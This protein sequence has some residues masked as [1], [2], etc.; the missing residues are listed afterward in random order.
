MTGKSWKPEDDDAEKKRMD[1][2][3]RV[4]E[5]LADGINRDPTD[6]MD[7]FMEAVNEA[8]DMT[9]RQ[10][11]ILAVA[12]R[13]FPYL[14]LTGV[15]DTIVTEKIKKGE[16]VTTPDPN[17]LRGIAAVRVAFAMEKEVRDAFVPQL[18][19]PEPDSKP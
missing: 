9:A 10:Q 3:L 1:N 6:H 11:I 17:V 18:L 7:S 13:V 4:A 19:P 14:D 2:L 15:L 16:L 5:K 8:M 12:G